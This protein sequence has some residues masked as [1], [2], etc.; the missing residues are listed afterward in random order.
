M[1]GSYARERA[2]HKQA[3]LAY[4]GTNAKPPRNVRA[5]QAKNGTAGSTV[6]LNAKRPA[7]PAS[8]APAPNKKPKMAPMMAKTLK[9]ARGIKGFRR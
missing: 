4:V 8:A 7:A 3:K 5:A 1:Q 9:R 2:Q 6:G